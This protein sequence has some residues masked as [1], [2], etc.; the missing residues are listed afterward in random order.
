MGEPAVVLEG[1]GNDE[2]AATLFSTVH[3]AGRALSRTAAAGRP[4]KRWVNDVRDDAATY[5]SKADALAVPGARRARTIRVREGG[6][7][8]FAS[9]R[10]ELADRGIELRGGAA[11]EAPGAY[12]RLDAV[13]RHHAGT[14]R[15]LHTLTPL[16]VA[17]AGEGT[18]DP[19]KD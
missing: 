8:D 5:P 11:D 1:V 19:Y 10:R 6:A 4:R 18:Y 7:I 17:M 12:K 9:V 13:L 3:G 2:A 14:V 15:I 16:G